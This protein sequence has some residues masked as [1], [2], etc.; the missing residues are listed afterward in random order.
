[1]RT[2]IAALIYLSAT[3][4]VASIDAGT[5]DAAGPAA[6]PAEG[7]GADWPIYRGNRSLQGV[8][9]G[10]IADRPE[11]IWTYAVNE[12]IAS[13]PVIAGGMVYVGADDGQLH[14]V[15]LESGTAVWTFKTEDMIEA[16]PLVHDG[17]V[18]VGSSDGYF[19]AVDAADGSLLWKYE[20]AAQILGSANIVSPE[21]GPERV[22]V[23]SYDASLYCFDMQTGEL[24][25]AYETADR[26]NGAPAVFGDRIVIGGCDAVLHVVSATTGESVKQMEMGEACHIA[27]SVGIADNRAYFCHYGNEFV[28]LDLEQEELIW[29]YPS[30]NQPFFSSPAIGA[31]VVLFGGRD[32]RLHCVDRISGKAIWTHATR[33]KIDTAPVLCGDRVVFTCGDG[34]IRIVDLKD[35]KETWVYDIGKPIISS[36]AVSDG[37]ILTGA[38]DGRLYAFGTPKKTGANER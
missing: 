17:R 22:I 11:L 13:S 28:C 21:S 24:L 26:L 15:E 23:G 2:L 6:A 31:D 19:Y 30:N 20:T 1:M 25:W 7:A 14:C 12:A 35:G 3:A 4:W 8:A 29:A 9:A 34:R 5:R 32:K 18:F 27:A 37:W 16:P 33:R 38:N 36:P 10:R